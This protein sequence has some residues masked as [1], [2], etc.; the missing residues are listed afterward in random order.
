M[1]ILNN[2]LLSKW[3]SR[4]KKNFYFEK[5]SSSLEINSGQF[6]NIIE[7]ILG[8]VSVNRLMRSTQGNTKAEEYMPIILKKN[9]R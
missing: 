7:I 4:A 5:I 6:E 2:Y 1:S 3:I 9:I 8:I